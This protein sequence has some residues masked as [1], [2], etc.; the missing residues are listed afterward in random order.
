MEYSQ[1][2]QVWATGMKI[3][4]VSWYPYTSSQ[5]YGVLA[6]GSWDEEVNSFAL[7][8]FEKSDDHSDC[9]LIT[10]SRTDSSITN[11]VSLGN[12]KFLVATTNGTLGLWRSNGL[13][14]YID[15]HQATSLPSL[16]ETKKWKVHSGGVKSVDVIN[17]ADLFVTVGADNNLCLLQR[18]NVLKKA[19]GIESVFLNDV[20]F[21]NSSTI[22]TCGRSIKIWDTH[23]DFT[24]P[25]L[26]LSGNKVGSI[27]YS[28][29][30][31]PNQSFYIASGDSD[32]SFDIWDR[33][34]YSWPIFK[35]IAQK[36][37]IWNVVF[38]P[39]DPSILYSVSSHDVLCWDFNV[40]KN[41]NPEFSTKEEDLLIS[42]MVSHSHT[43][44][45][46][47][48]VLPSINSLCIGSDSE[49]LIFNDAINRK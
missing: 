4:S 43:H 44:M 39:S 18:G 41:I 22:V 35:K 46:Q 38:H 3:N 31:H 16:V 17:D 26:S 34:N 23:Q 12:E 49:Q 40:N 48:T 10:Q 30:V 14:D 6:S 29:A 25:V 7:W 37:P 36:G 1:D 5:S 27:M 24:K 20:K 2:Y 19:I 28:V 47:I 8:N 11:V 9:K 45:N 15:S 33:R 42:K 32:G 21:I 13:N